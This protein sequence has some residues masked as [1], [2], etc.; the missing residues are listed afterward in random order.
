MPWCP[1]CK[2]EYRE[3]M[4]TCADCKIALVDSLDDIDHEIVTCELA[5]MKHKDAVIRLVNYL[6]YS[7]IDYVDVQA[8]LETRTYQILVDT[9]V[10]KEA[11]KHY[12]AFLSVEDQMKQ[13]SESSAEINEANAT[14][15][16]EYQDLI[17]FDILEDSDP[18][19]EEEETIA[20]T[21]SSSSTYV[22]K[23]DAYKD[24][25][26]TGTM[27]LGFSILG[28]VFVGLNIAGVITFINGLFSY[29]V[30]SGLFVGFFLLGI[31]SLKRA[32]EVSGDI[33]AENQ[34]TADINAYLDNLGDLTSIDDA[35]WNGLND[36]IL[37]FKRTNRL[38]EM[39]TAKFGTLND[40][41]LDCIIEEYY[42]EH[43]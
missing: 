16:T 38:K 1:K 22:K 32:K 25:H 10:R 5:V 15:Y 33:D 35:D 3:G 13:A 37:Y 42:N 4:T 26:S 23:E 17:D 21:A 11:M 19:S 24:N 2:N 14:A 34:M 27:F 43:I 40:D 6:R 12:K 39:I 36:E 28:F 8:D 20:P 29:L 31:Y 41:Y 7:G 9:S 30:M 18:V